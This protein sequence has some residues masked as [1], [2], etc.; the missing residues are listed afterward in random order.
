MAQEPSRAEVQQRIHNL[1]DRAETDTGNFN[2][3]RAMASGRRTRVAPVPGAGRGRMDPALDDIVKPWFDVA[4]AKLGPT[5]PAVL[6]PELRPDRLPEARPSLPAM[7]PD[8]V[9]PDR[10]REPGGRG[11]P[12]LTAGPA[13][14]TAPGPVAELPAAPLA[15]LPAGPATELTAVPAAGL[16]AGPL[17][18]LPAAPETGRKAS[19][20]RPASADETRQSSL[21]A[22]KDKNRRKLA[23][24][25]ELLSGHVAQWSTPWASIELPPADDAWHATAQQARHVAEV[26]ADWQGQGPSGFGA[27]MST[28]TV[29]SP[30]AAMST[31]TVMSPGTTTSA[32]TVMSPGTDWPA[33]T[34]PSLGAGLAVGALGDLGTSGALRTVGT[35]GAVGAPVTGAGGKAMAAVEFAR[36]QIGKPCVWGA[37]GPGSYDCSSL[38]RAAWKTAGV[39]LPRTAQDQAYAGSAIA[40][41]DVQP[42]DLVFFTDNAGHVGI[43]VG[44]G[45]MVH[46]PSQG[47]H[48]REDPILYAGESAIHSVVRPV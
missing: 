26:E 23:A 45:M 21:R 20:A 40:L 48:V 17:A 43:C 13:A 16:T 29:M 12:E 14:E 42:G 11:L 1:Y 25:R 44:N 6:P 31:S 4:R 33:G 15:E 47:P 24:A 36:A 38:T 18:G 10:A 30:G 32:G 39:T 41:S 2:A 22:A 5:V 9:R 35:S 37:T 8:D 46:A 34:D 28:G 3:T 27:V 19:A 7:R